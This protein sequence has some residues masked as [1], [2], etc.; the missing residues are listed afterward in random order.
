VA[1][2][3]SA[4]ALGACGHHGDGLLKGKI[5]LGLTTT[6]GT[7]P[8]DAPKEAERAISEASVTATQSDAADRRAV[9]AQFARL[10]SSVPPSL[11]PSVAILR[12]AFTKVWADPRSDAFDSLAYANADQAILRYVQ[13]G[14]PPDAG[15]TTSAP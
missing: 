4:L 5:D 6:T 3:L 14:C 7:Q 2:A 9:V 11:Q 1:L 13:A 12:R 15:T 8:C 10:T